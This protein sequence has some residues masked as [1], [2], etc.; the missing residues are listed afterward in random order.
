VENTEFLANSR[1][2]H[3]VI[4]Q[5][6]GLECIGLTNSSLFQ[7]RFSILRWRFGPLKTSEEDFN[8]R[9]PALSRKESVFLANLPGEFQLFPTAP[10]IIQMGSWNM[11]VHTFCYFLFL[12]NN[13]DIILLSVIHWIYFKITSKTFKLSC[14][15]K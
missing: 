12:L 14:S 2:F 7:A 10:D 3:L 11:W 9:S 4:P 1:C 5:Q 8:Q 13:G 6:F 15:W